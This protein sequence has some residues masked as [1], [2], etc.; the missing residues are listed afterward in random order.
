MTQSPPRRFD[1][2]LTAQEAYPALE[3]AFAEAKREIIAGFRVF[4]PWT[5]LRSDRARRFGD[6]W[7]DLIV[8]TLN[9]GVRI[10]LILSDFDPVVRQSMHAYAWDCLRG[11]IAAGE[12]STHP[13]HLTV[14]TSMHP[15]RVGTLLRLVLWPRSTKEIRHGLDQINGAAPEKIDSYL[16]HVPYLR[17]MLKKRG[18]KLVPRWR[19]PALVPV[20]HHQ[21]IAV[22]DTETL[23]AGGLDLNDRRYDTPQH[24]QPA[25][26]TWHDTQVMVTGPVAQE[27]A[28][29]LRSFE[30][31][32]AGRAPQPMRHLLR[33][34]SARRT[35]S[36]PY[37]SPKPVVRELADAHASQIGQSDA[38][39][40]LE[41]QFFRDQAL[42]RQLAKRARDNTDL[43]LILILPAAPEEVA[44]ED[45]SSPDVA[46][47]EHL[48]V[49]A[50]KVIEEA[51]G[52]RL[53]I[54]SPAQPRPAKPD[55]RATHFGAPLIYLHAKVSIFDRR[56]AIV[57]SANLNGRSMAWDTEVGVQTHSAD[58]VHTLTTRCFEHWLGADAGPAFFDV[59]TACAAWAQR[60]RQNAEVSPAD[61][62]GFLLPYDKAPAA[63][64]GYNLPGVPEEMA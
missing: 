37:L 44:F 14:R 38:L 34:I 40:Y 36:W 55:G 46:Y 8:D 43:T 64:L 25:A 42:A 39:I 2:L 12:A 52:P 60:A 58:E 22:F 7:F 63:A 28:D 23:Y 48:Q 6:T 53:F 35:W 18:A 13:E 45:A 29:H 9:R 30:A 31:I 15:A 27:A 50:I 59:K 51:F 26:Q 10:T 11:L 16:R 3:T 17:P 1:V 5:K 33:T 61:R 41:S 49:K 4:D 21:K 19:P 20:T 24:D 32:T 57:S 47:G 56:A 54:G 62:T